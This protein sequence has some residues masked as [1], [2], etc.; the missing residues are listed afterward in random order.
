MATTPHNN[1]DLYGYILLGG[2]RS[3]GVVTL[4]GHDRAHGWEDQKPKGTAGEYTVN[5]G[6]QNSSFTATFLLAD[7]EDVEAWDTFQRLLDSSL[8]GPKPRALP[9]Y[10]PD[11]ARNRI[12]D[13]V[14]ESVGGMTHAKDGGMTVVCKFKEFRPPKPKAPAKPVAGRSRPSNAESR[15]DPNADAKRELAALL[16]QAKA[17]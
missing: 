14:V 4:T 10:H 13:V 16:E 7:L 9:V 5:R 3:P 8:S 12:T 17:P 15:P 1:P 6:P 11:L 2:S